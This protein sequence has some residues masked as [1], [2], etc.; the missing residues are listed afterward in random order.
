MLDNK[1]GYAFIEIRE[2]GS[3]KEVYLSILP[4]FAKSSNTILLY[5]VK[6]KRL[7]CLTSNL[8]NFY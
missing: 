6:Q 8:I 7:C 4:H 1:K 3:K 2:K 5:F